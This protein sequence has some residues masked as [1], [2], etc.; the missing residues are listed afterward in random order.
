MV[1]GGGWWRG[2]VVG[3]GERSWVLVVGGSPLGDEPLL[4][5]NSVDM[6]KIVR[7]FMYI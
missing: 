2:E 4:S 3:G 5:R 7:I 6:N 1:V